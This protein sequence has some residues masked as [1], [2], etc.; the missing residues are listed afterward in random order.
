[1]A[2]QIRL[3]LPDDLYKTLKEQAEADDRQIANY[4]THLLKYIIKEYNKKPNR[5]GMPSTLMG[6]VQNK[7]DGSSQ[8]PLYFPQWV[9][10]PVTQPIPP[11]PTPVHTMPSPENPDG[12]PIITCDTN[13]SERN[14]P[15][16]IN[17]N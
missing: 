6:F 1:M 3:T 8:S 17:K 13:I 12:R 5:P 16:Y 11:T 4:I 7:M 9:R 14:R 15:K 10:T 2:K